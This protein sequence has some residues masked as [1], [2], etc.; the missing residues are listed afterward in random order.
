MAQDDDYYAVLGV[1]RNANTDAIKKAYRRCAIQ[2]HPD[3]NPGDAQAEARFKACAEAY[4][5]L[6]DPDKRARYD[7]FGKEG[8]RGAGVHDWAHADVHDIF[9]MFEEVFGFGDIFGGRRSRT[10]PKAGQ[11]LRCTIDLTLEEVLSGIDKTIR[12][13]RHELCEA[14]GGTGSAS[15]KRQTCPTCRGQGRVQQ[16]GGFFRVV[17]ACPHCGG[18]GSTVT[19]PCPACGGNR[20][21]NRK[22]TIEVTIPP[23]LEDGQQIRYG[24]QGDAG[25]PGAPAGDLM[26]VVRVTEHPL[27]ERHGRDLL[28]QVPIDFTQ[29]ALGATIEV[30]TLEGGE[31]IEVGRGTQSGDL[32]RLE[33]RGL[34]DVRTGRR[35]DVLVQ[36]IVEVPKKLS[37]RQEELLHEFGDADKRGAMPLRNGYLKRL[38]AYRRE[39]ARAND[40]ADEDTRDDA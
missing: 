29:A 8:L 15:G 11:S 36:V 12:L 25:E 19:D 28:C 14:C 21:V 32:Y 18:T 1:D 35:G 4:E 31:T 30:V 33:G 34:P 23:G 16:G 26:A 17:R 38:D 24:G 7:R 3:R 27:F 20:F 13:T 39:R 22:R 40:G 2:Y 10:G 9:S 6:S 5:V 37:R